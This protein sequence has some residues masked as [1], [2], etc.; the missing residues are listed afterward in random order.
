MHF[1]QMSLCADASTKSAETK[2]DVAHVFLPQAEHSRPK[3]QQSIAGHAPHGAD[4]AVRLTIF[5]Q[6][7]SSAPSSH[8]PTAGDVIGEVCSG[9][10]PS[11]KVGTGDVG[12]GSS[13]GSGI[14]VGEDGAGT[15]L[16][17]ACTLAEDEAARGS[18]LRTIDAESAE[19]LGQNSKKNI[20]IV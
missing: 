1:S 3:M 7:R 5:C 12:A 19:S 9:S 20:K 15:T 18:A 13:V 8:A 14:S 6:I 4:K 10:F 2:A 17:Y 11:L 16:G